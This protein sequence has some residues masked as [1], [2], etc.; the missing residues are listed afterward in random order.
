M[1]TFPKPLSQEEERQLLQKYKEG[2][3]KAK[4]RLIEHNLRLVAHIVKKYQN[5]DEDLQDLISVG[6]IGLIKAVSTFDLERGKLCT[7]GARCI[8]NA[9]LTQKRIC[10][11]LVV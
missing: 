9:I 3:Q 7:Y 11:E 2:D 4:E 10:G 5:S 8:E 6:T 1:N